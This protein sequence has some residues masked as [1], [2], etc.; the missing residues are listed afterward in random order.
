VIAEA[1]RVSSGWAVLRVELPSALVEAVSSFLFDEGANGILTEDDA[2]PARIEA[3]V[4][5]AEKERVEAALGRYLAALGQVDAVVTPVEVAEVDWAAVARAHHRPMA[6]GKRLLIAPPWD[7][8]EAGGRELLVLEPG[9]AF[10]TGQHA[11]TRTCLEAIEELVDAGGIAS[12]LDVGTGS[13]ILAL[14]LARLGV[15]DVVA[16]DV[17]PAV[18]PIARATLDANGAAGVALAGGTAVTIARRFDVVVANLLAGTIVAEAD[19]LAR[20]VAAGGRLVLSGILADQAAAVWAAFPAWDLA[21][22]RDADGWSTLT[23]VRTR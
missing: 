4:P 14:A 23:L 17:D 18:L 6:V 15:P 13:G 19:V 11:T 2:E 8:P 10:G 7:V 3:S 1:G 16:V 20:T 22:R 21:G 12:A 9:M 5:A